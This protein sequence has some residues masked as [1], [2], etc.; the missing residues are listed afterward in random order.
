MMTD[1]D[2]PLVSV[3]TASLDPPHDKLIRCIESVRRQTYDRVQHVIVDGLS[4]NGALEVM[5]AYSHL[6][7]IAEPDEGQSD[8]VNKGMF[9]YSDGE[10]VVW[11]NAD[12]V[13]YEDSIEHA[14]GLF[15]THPNV[16]WIYGD[17]DVDDNGKRRVLKASP[18]AERKALDFNNT[19]LIAPGATF[20]RTALEAAGPM[21]RDFRMEMDMHLALKLL[22]AGV[23]GLYTPRPLALFEI[24]GGTKTGEIS[25]RD[26]VYERHEIYLRHGMFH[27]AG[28]ALALAGRYEISDTIEASLREGDY[29]AAAAAARKGL[30]YMTP[31]LARHRI[32]F[33]LA[34]A[35]PRAMATIKRIKGR[36]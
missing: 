14:V 7:V 23:K 13:L 28:A 31:I 8:A 35:F 12:D 17:L 20:R 4:S 30:R 32:S 22:E 16:G 18:V 11:L 27:Q 3:V 5:K 1:S 10:Y 34:A 36:I 25:K 2:R 24:F 26:L 21:E 6:K 33:A 15:Q 19:L 9:Q 29:E